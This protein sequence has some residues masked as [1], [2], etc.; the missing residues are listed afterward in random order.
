MVANHGGG[1]SYRLCPATGDPTEACFEAH[2]LS[3]ATAEHEILDTDGKLVTRFPANILSNGT[4]P[5]GSEWAVNPIPLEYGMI[6]AIPGLASLFGRGPFPY[7]VVDSV[8]VPHLPAGHYILSWRWDSEQVKQVWSQCA[9]IAIVAPGAA[10]P[11]TA[12]ASA[13]DGSHFDS[14]DACIGNSVGLDVLECAA[15]V[16]LYDSLNGP[17]WIGHNNQTSLAAR[18]DPCGALSDWWK[19]TVVCELFPENPAKASPI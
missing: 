15:W 11:D 6:S 14:A 17:G 9:D 2:T 1:Y 13:A 8:K 10:A 7:S 18:T 4:H 5:K 3:F 12:L 19:K 16:Q